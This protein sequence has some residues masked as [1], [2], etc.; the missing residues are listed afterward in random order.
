MIT[1]YSFNVLLITHLK[2]RLKCIKS[3]N[4]ITIPRNILHSSTRV[5]LLETFCII[6]AFIFS[7][8]W[9]NS[10]VKINPKI[11]NI[12]YLITREGEINYDDQVHITKGEYAVILLGDES[13]TEEACGQ[14]IIIIFQF[15]FVYLEGKV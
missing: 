4:I 6:N 11:T 7:G 1:S 3:K 14:F 12:V 10:G 15:L 5:L 9:Y 8:H 13:S 2:T